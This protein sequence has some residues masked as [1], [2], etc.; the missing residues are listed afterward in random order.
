MVKGYLLA[1]I[2]AVVTAASPAL[3]QAD[4]SKEAGAVEES[5]TGLRDI[6]VTA[7]RRAEPLQQTPLAVSA[8]D[9]VRLDEANV[10]QLADMTS[11]ARLIHEPAALG[12]FGFGG[13]VAA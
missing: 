5:S 6:V 13:S 7:R 11:L 1:S 3:A 10:S 9:S 8:I 12:Y 2:C 4:I